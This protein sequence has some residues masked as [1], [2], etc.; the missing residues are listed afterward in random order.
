MQYS[1][2]KA[3]FFVKKKEKNGFKRGSFVDQKWH[4]RMM[5]VPLSQSKYAFFVVFKGIFVAHK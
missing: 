1:Y 2:R 5:K 3:S 4:F